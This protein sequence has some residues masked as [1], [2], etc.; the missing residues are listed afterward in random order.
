M[1]EPYKYFSL[2]EL[3]CKCGKCGSTGNEMDAAFMQKLILLRGELRIP[4]V[5]SSAYRCPAHNA[6]ESSTGE[7]G[8]HTT[9]KAVDILM[10]GADALKLIQYAINLGFTGIGIK[11]HGISRFIHVDT[12]A[13]PDYPRPTVW[14]YQ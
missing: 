7:T 12:L 13:A 4:F 11:Q 10:R 3:K 2:S 8:P 6:K 5:L 14:S 1:T 9:G